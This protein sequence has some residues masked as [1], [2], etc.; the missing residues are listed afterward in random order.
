MAG[1]L[2]TNLDVTVIERIGDNMAL[3]LSVLIILFWNFLINRYWTY[4]D[5][6]KM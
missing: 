2:F 3:A 5:V 4:S 1:N 6:D